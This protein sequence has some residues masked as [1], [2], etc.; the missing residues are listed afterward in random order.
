MLTSLNI[1][2]E[3]DEPITPQERN[4]G[5]SSP[6]KLL[7]SL[8]G[9][10]ISSIPKKTIGGT[11]SFM[12]ST[13]RISAPTSPVK[14]PRPESTLSR[15]ESIKIKED[16]EDG[17]Y[18]GKFSIANLE[19]TLATF[20]LALHSRKGNVV[21]KVLRS[22]KFA[23]HNAVNEL[24]DGLLS[25][26]DDHTTPAQA[27]VDILFAAF[28]RFLNGAWEKVMGPIVSIG[29]LAA[30]QEKSEQL[31]PMEFVEF[32]RNTVANMAPQNQRA[33]RKL[34]KLLTDLLDGAGNDGDRGILTASFAEVL[35]PGRKDAL[36]YM[37]LLDRLVDDR[38]LLFADDARSGTAT[39]NNDS[40]L[41]EGRSRTGNL[42]SIS[43]NTS[44]LRRRL[45]L[46]TLTREN[47]RNDGENKSPSVWRTLSKSARGV[48]HQNGSPSK[49]SLSRAKSI[50][51]DL[52]P[53]PKRPISR[54]KPNGLGSFKFESPSHDG[55]LFPGNKSPGAAAGE[56]EVSRAAGPPRKKRRSSLSDLTTL[57]SGNNTPS[58]SPLT[59]RNQH[60]VQSVKNHI[61]NLENSPRTPSPTKQSNIPSLKST[62][63]NRKEDSP[64]QSSVRRQGATTSRP[65]SMRSDECK[66]PALN[67]HKRANGLSGIPSLKP[68]SAGTNVV[69]ALSERPTGGNSSKP[70]PEKHST[71]TNP[72]SMTGAATTTTGG[73]PSPQKQ[74]MQSPQKLRR[75]LQNEQK[76]VGSVEAS[77]QAELSKI[78]D[79]MSSS[80]HHRASRNVLKPL[81]SATDQHHA[82]GSTVNGTAN[83]T[84][85]GTANG[86]SN[87]THSNSHSPGKV[88]PALSSLPQSA[89]TAQTRLKTVEA[90]TTSQINDVKKTLATLALDLSSSLEVS[91]ERARRLDEL[92]KAAVAEN[93]ALSVKYNEELRKVLDVAV[94]GGGGGG[95]GER[96]KKG[97][98]ELVALVGRKIRD[99]G[100]EAVAAKKEVARL[101]RENAGLRALVRKE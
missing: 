95:G 89:S 99:V 43:S 93:E 76:V 90:R 79:E 36:N 33:F 81:A 64:L 94:G 20:V 80:L 59:P 44:S 83:G 68:P 16:T 77:L 58:W 78:E 19:Q 8:F 12:N 53:S 11:T 4:I 41:F 69:G 88:N 7:S 46:G 42:G 54:D 40:T 22:R 62:P 23:D 97:P 61:N 100:D 45:G 72:T 39:P 82:P 15:N 92:Y 27:S 31:T 26:P 6:V 66:V 48:E 70:P 52:R 25:R 18:D 37:S 29:D 24:H 96:G 56:S 10:A 50:E 3:P 51:Q 65:S 13:Y 14:Q 98:E 74:R 1:E 73:T 28:E 57:A 30:I 17:R 91:E 9:G 55:K 71:G 32:F 67:I 60:S 63:N 84:T 87:G 47:S 5:P 85:N 38:Q 86:T 34:M 2:V 35:V 49:A 101:R 75:R 21:G